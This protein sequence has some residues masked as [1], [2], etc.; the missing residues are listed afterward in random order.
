[1]GIYDALRC[2]GGGDG[3]APKVIGLFRFRDGDTVQ[4]AMNEAT[5]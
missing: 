4:D 5:N 1:M 2:H 3:P